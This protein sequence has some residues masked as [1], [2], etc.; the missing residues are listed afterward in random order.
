MIINKTTYAILL[1]FGTLSISALPVYADEHIEGIDWHTLP[2][3]TKENLAPVADRWDKLKPHQQHKLVRRAKDK[4]FKNRAERWKKLSPEQRQRIVKAR[5]RFKDMPPEKRKELR[6]RWENMSDKDKRE[7]KAQR[8][9]DKEQR[10]RDKAQRH[11]NKEQRQKDKAQRHKDKNK[12]S[13]KAK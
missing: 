4:T 11:N 1:L 2:A 8:H 13:E 7:A 6:K 10:Q 3:E 12:D 9:K 5:D